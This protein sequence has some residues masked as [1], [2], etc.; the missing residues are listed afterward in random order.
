MR[1]L[2]LVGV[3]VLACLLAA[4]TAYAG[5]I[6]VTKSGN[7]TTGDGSA[8]APYLTIQKGITS[9]TN[10]DVVVVGEGTYVERIS[11]GGKAI[12]VR[13][14]NPDSAGVVAATII[15]GGAGGPVVTF[16]G[17]EGYSS[18]I[19][20][21]TITN[22]SATQG[23]GIYCG[24]AS[25]T[26]SKNV[27]TANHATGANTYDGGG[28]IFCSGNPVIDH[29][30]ITNNTARM[31][32]AI[33][34]AMDSAATIACNTIQNNTSASGG[35]GIYIQSGGGTIASNVIDGNS[36]TGWLG[37]GILCQSP[38][39]NVAIANNTITNN[40]AGGGG[41]I[42]FS[43][44]SGGTVTGNVIK[45]NK[46]I[47]ND[48]NSGG[49]GIECRSYASG[50]VIS[51]NIVCGNISA[52]EG[53]GAI[54]C[55]GTGTVAVTN[56]TVAHNTLLNNYGGGLTATWGSAVTIKNC[57]IY[58]NEAP[59][60]TGTQLAV[61]GNNASLNVSYSDVQSGESAVYNDGATATFGD[62]NVDSNPLFAALGSWIDSG[63]PT[64][65]LDDAWSGGDWHEKST[66]GRWDE[67]ADG[68][69]GAWV[70]DAVSSPCIDAGDPASAYD[71]EESP[72]GARI[73]QGAYGNTAFASKTP[74]CHVT[75]AAAPPGTATTT[76][77][78]GTH[79]FAFG[80]TFA[81]NATFSAGT[82]V[83]WT[84][85]PSENASFANANAASTTVTVTG[86]VTVTA[87]MD[88]NLPAPTFQ[89]AAGDYN[90][91]KS[92]TIS[93]ATAGASIRYTTNGNTPTSDS[94][95]CS[96][97]VSVEATTTIKAIALKAGYINSPVATAIYRIDRQAPLV[98][99][100]ATVPTQ[101]RE[102]VDNS[103]TL[104]ATGNDTDTGGCKISAAE[105]F[106]GTDPG[107]GR[108]TAMT[109]VD[110]A[111]S[112]SVESVAATVNTSSWSIGTETMKVRVRDNAGNWSSAGSITVDI[113][114]GTPPGRVN[115][116]RAT[117]VTSMPVLTASVSDHSA[118]A[119]GSFADALVDGNPSTLWQSLSTAEPDTHYITLDLGSVKSV[120]GVTLTPGVTRALFPATFSVLT[121]EDGDEW[122][123]ILRVVGHKATT[124]ASW[125]FGAVDAR[126]VKISGPGVRNSAD[127]KYCWQ[128]ADVAALRSGTC[129]ANL[130]WTAPADDGSLGTAAA[131]YDVRYALSSI[132]SGTFADATRVDDVSAP[133]A[134]GSTEHL[135]I[136][137][138]VHSGT[139][140][141]AMKTADEVD[142]WSAMSNEPSVSAATLAVK[143]LLPADGAGVTADVIPTFSFA[144]DGTATAPRIAFSTAA[145]FA[146]ATAKALSQGNGT[147]RFALPAGA[148]SFTPTAA[149]WKSLK[150]I[151]SAEGALYWRVECTLPTGLVFGPAQSVVFNTG[152]LTLNP[153]AG[154]HA[155]GSDEAI[156][157]V[158]ATPP[159]F[160]WN[161]NTV[162]MRYFY[163]Q[164]SIEASMT[165]AKPK[166][167][168]TFP[169]K[170][171]TGANYTLRAADW[172]AVRKL[173]TAGGGTLYWRV[174]AQDADK[175]LVCMSVPS[176]VIVDI[177]QW[178]LID[179]A[180]PA[181]GASVSCSHTGDGIVT[182]CLQF[183][184]TDAFT[185][186]ARTLMTLPSKPIATTS[187]TLTAAQVKVLKA[188][189]TRA[190]RTSL[191]YR[192]VGRDA[193]RSFVG[194]SEVKAAT[195]AQ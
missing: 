183:S 45:G 107:A 51:S 126:Y 113:V 159:T 34:G 117:A 147:L 95:L 87:N 122:T 121:S 63:T 67:A 9:A 129:F 101:I 48:G 188:F 149:R 88:V 2:K 155:T 37:G 42:C 3:F 138:G 130:A 57:I 86:N 11:F 96:G 75:M 105:Y 72:N 61:W 145:T 10:S 23:G 151:A 157:P 114:D 15:D 16:S 17:A 177:G 25:P 81:I 54:M 194:Y 111:F 132:G 115:D 140:Y 93:C 24:A 175:A 191:Y 64:N 172:K 85:S 77:A 119:P 6:Y 161:N 112:S 179:A 185:A 174:K 14:T 5:N 169:K 8:G 19:S 98:G 52:G 62:G 166:Q 29:N 110:G 148:T 4:G 150:K 168:L 182:H 92:V 41:G 127:G 136:D 156:W 152:A 170:G 99:S 83:N 181:A 32:A 40:L 91:T 30:T 78:A 123:T 109:A 103:L 1:D 27:I 154:S 58:G 53:G 190:G 50:V 56:C 160:S 84:A 21:F 128:L 35:A 33:K 60:A 124:A 171:V 139:V 65:R 120:H 167:L 12:T 49:G 100:I 192:A 94:T 97:A 43:E 118:S 116:L 193:D 153:I 38:G 74:G 137:L 55:M 89:P 79:W 68:G 187:Y 44:G 173:A 180:L 102:H 125:L 104:T 143:P 90:V 108:G 134:P 141:F 133:G 163:V 22:G 70:T 28:G 131:Q 13:S 80:D 26:I 36:T 18:V 106:R 76:P 47:S 178:A 142:N 165:P 39:G 158:K 184:T 66:E 135:L 20:G 162:G 195:F 69:A 82:F 31:G 7:D 164:V 146:P 189:A 59:H 186:G 73:N 144:V 46:G 176:K 71:N